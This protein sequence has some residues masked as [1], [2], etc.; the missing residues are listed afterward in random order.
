MVVPWFVLGSSLV[1]YPRGIGKVQWEGILRKGSGASASG[2]ANR[3]GG[4]S[5][6]AVLTSE[7]E[8]KAE[9]LVNRTKA[10]LVQGN[11][12]KKYEQHCL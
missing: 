6:A 11:N 8:E 9:Y 2:V 5:V 12:K 4:G 10:R 7:R 1:F 3:R